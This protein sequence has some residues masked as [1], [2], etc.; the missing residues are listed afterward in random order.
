MVTLMTL[1]EI[2]DFSPLLA[3]YSL[4]LLFF[5]GA[6]MG[7]FTNCLQLRL[8]NKSGSVFGRSACPACS[9][10]LGL[11]DLFPVF[12]YL[13]LRGKCRYCREK[14]SPRYFAVEV[15]FGLCYA[16][17]LADLGFGFR[18]LE[19]LLLFTLLGAS[20]LCDLT[21]FEVPDSLAIAEAA[22]FLVFS[23]T[24]PNPIERILWGLLA[25]LVYGGG[26]LALSLLADK[27]YQK[28]TLGGAD[29]KLIA[30]L[31]LYFGMSK[32]LFLVIISAIIGIIFAYLAKAGLAKEFPFIPSLAA[33]AFVT[34]LFGEPFIGWYLGLF[35][36]HVH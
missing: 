9:H 24:Y 33:G 6:C 32:M 14:I 18:L 30:V 10:T 36:M 16:G 21:T 8:Q 27:I 5:T 19:Y 2:Y 15:V 23:L 20:S 7:S 1:R 31:G 25:A 29:I 13:F 28:D 35:H 11:L 4:V 12:S 22:A 26:V 17:L 3:V 34:L